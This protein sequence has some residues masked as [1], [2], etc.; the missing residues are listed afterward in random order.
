MNYAKPQPVMGHPITN[1]QTQG[2]NNFNFAQPAQNPQFIN[3]NDSGVIEQNENTMYGDTTVINNRIY[4]Q[5]Q[6]KAGYGAMSY[7]TSP[8]KMSTPINIRTKE[9][10]SI[11]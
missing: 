1:Y 9:T 5:Q 11:G 2:N 7:F 3:Y 10:L 8:Q 4:N 6:N